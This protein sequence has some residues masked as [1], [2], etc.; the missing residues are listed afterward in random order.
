VSVNAF[1]ASILTY[2]DNYMP[3][4][5]FQ[6]EILFDEAPS[7]SLT[8][9]NFDLYNGGSIATLIFVE[10][11]NNKH[12]FVYFNIPDVDEGNYYLRLKNVKY[13]EGEILKSFNK[14][15]EFK[16][17]NINQ[18]F[19][20]LVENQ[21]NDGSFGNIKETSLVAIA[22]KNV[23]GE[24]ANDAISYLVSN[25]DPLGCY[26]N[27]NCNVID[28]SLAMITLKKFNQNYIKTKNWL[29][30][31]GNNFD[32][33]SWQLEA[34]GNGACSYNDNDYTINGQSTL[35]ILSPNINFSCNSLFSFNLKHNYLGSSYN[36]F[37][38]SGN[39]FTYVIDDSG[40][41][42]VSYRKKCDY[43]STLY[44]SWA[45][46]EAGENFPWDYLVNNRLDNR[47]IDHALGYIIYKDIYSKDWL[48][49]NQINSYWSYYSASISQTPDYYT[50]ALS[51]YALKDEIVF[52]DAKNYLKTKTEDNVLT[53]SMILSLLFDDQ[54]KSNS[55]SISP[56]IVNN[57]NSFDLILTDNGNPTTV[58]IEAP[59]F[60]GLP[61]SVN[62]IESSVFKVNIPSN[63]E[64]FEIILEYSNKSYTI[65]VIL[66][67]VSEGSVLLPP[68]KD[69][70]KFILDKEVVNI[71]MNKKD[72]LMD[73]IKFMNNWDIDISNVSII[74]TGNLGE[75]IELDDNHF[76]IV[77]SGGIV[78]TEITINSNRNPEF[79][80][81]QGFVVL[82]SEKTVDSFGMILN[83]EENYEGTSEKV[84]DEG[85][86]EVINGEENKIDSTKKPVEKKSS[87][88]WLWVIIMVITGITVFLFF[89]R[90]RTIEE[91][92]GDFIKK[93]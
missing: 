25:L 49:N 6:A 87:L 37:Q 22:L 20:Y 68:P 3:G 54:T 93:N 24:E 70:L 47:T 18:G 21:K 46:K 73:E 74:L 60:T 11:L 80:N 15:K 42:G 88:W 45:L 65:P 75:I 69:A 23:Y 27:G 79:N 8:N 14:N 91:D 10:K 72:I 52:G 62:L 48:L 64:S 12:Y 50:S 5:T 59:N 31:A 71:T 4:E 56:G 28:T 92:I 85:N 57:K 26:P 39:N 30:D 55:I 13:L 34:N 33:G 16:I 51:T 58:L 35:D 86:E 81:Y 76:D 41:Y 9:V 40:C 61:S 90:K 36:I 84:F 77:I 19:D 78:S 17:S 89:R 67:D 38:M 82:K 66:E 32:V 29:G 63:Q 1:D 44:A 83:F 2:R 53:S 43:I 7:G